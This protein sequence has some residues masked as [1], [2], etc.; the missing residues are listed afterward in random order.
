MKMVNIGGKVVVKR[1]AIA[2]GEI[3]LKR[4]SIEAIKEGK[5]EKGDVMTVSKIA[6]IN[7]VKATAHTIPMCHP[8][9]INYVHIDLA[10][11]GYKVK[12]TCEVNAN[13][14][15]GVEMEAL[16]GV[17]IA[18]LNVWDMVKYLEKDEHGQYP[19]TS[20]QNIRVVSKTKEEI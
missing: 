8:I 7:A 15:T 11:T 9:P 4:K 17:S 6:G 2:S 1:T 5:I 3:L 10:I 12:C 18:L 13:Y 14:K 16:H 19:G 20:I